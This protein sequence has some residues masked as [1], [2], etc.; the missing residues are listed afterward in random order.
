MNTLLQSKNSKNQLKDVILDRDD[1]AKKAMGH[2]DKELES[3]RLEN[4]ILKEEMKTQSS[5]IIKLKAE[6]DKLKKEPAERESKSKK[7]G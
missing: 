3:L 5:M 4:D 6:N 1:I 2:E 7:R